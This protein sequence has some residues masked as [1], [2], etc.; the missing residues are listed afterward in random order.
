MNRIAMAVKLDQCCG[1][2]ACQTACKVENDLPPGVL[3]LKVTHSKLEP[4]DVRGELFMDRFPIPVTLTVCE[5]CLAK[6]DE[7]PLCSK[8]CMGKALY[9][10]TPEKAQA[11]AEDARSVVFTL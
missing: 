7:E 3:W 5:E 8:V 2:F 4:E 1:C 11:F 10:G 6:T 9:V